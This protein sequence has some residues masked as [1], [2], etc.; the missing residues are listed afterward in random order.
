MKTSA[1]VLRLL[2]MTLS[3]VLSSSAMRFTIRKNFP[4]IHFTHWSMLPTLFSLFEKQNKENLNSWSLRFEFNNKWLQFCVNKFRANPQSLIWYAEHDSTYDPPTILTS[5]RNRFN[6][7]WEAVEV[8]SLKITLTALEAC[9]QTLGVASVMIVVE[10][11][12]QQ[13]FRLVA[14]QLEHPETSFK[15]LIACALLWNFICLTWDCRRSWT[16]CPASAWWGK[17]WHR[18]ELRCST[19]EP[20]GARWPAVDGSRRP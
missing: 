1:C 6:R 9:H 8:K 10:R 17:C 3:F 20:A 14:H 15:C 5:L 4:T 2:M 13:V 18:A 7:I 11:F 12:P 19:D 16:S